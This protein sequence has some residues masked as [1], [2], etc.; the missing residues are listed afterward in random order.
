MGFLPADACTPRPSTFERS[1][2][3]FCGCGRYHL[4]LG[5]VTLDLTEAELVLLGRTVHEMAARRPELQAKLVASL[6]QDHFNRQ[7]AG[8]AKG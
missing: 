4:S 8:Q 2:I 3:Y 6:Y 5:P 7:D 1:R